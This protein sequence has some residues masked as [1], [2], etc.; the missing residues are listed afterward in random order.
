M[1]GV[2]EAFMGVNGAFQ[3]PSG[4]VMTGGCAAP[5]RTTSTA[6]AGGAFPQSGKVAPL[7][8]TMWSLMKPLTE[9]EVMMPQCAN[10]GRS[11]QLSSD[12]P[13]AQHP[14]RVRSVTLPDECALQRRPCVCVL[15][16]PAFCHGDTPWCRFRRTCGLT[17]DTPAGWRLHRQAW[18][19]SVCHFCLRVCWLRVPD[20]AR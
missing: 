17:N 14:D 3:E 7:W 20:H 2:N 15:F 13:I 9:Q 11:G 5:S 10:R 16:L 6:V 4:P 8:T 1:C 12:T 19:D 18:S